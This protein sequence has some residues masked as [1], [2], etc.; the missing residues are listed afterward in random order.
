[1]TTLI[2]PFFYES[3]S[4][5]ASFTDRKEERERLSRMFEEHGRRILLYGRRRMGK[6]SL[7][8]NCVPAKSLLI[9]VDVSVAASMEELAKQL[10]H[11][12]PRPDDA[13]LARALKI[14]A[15]HFKQVTLGAGGISIAG[16]L[17]DQTGPENLGQA[18]NAL[19]ELAADRDEVWTICLDEF[20]E[21]QKLGGEKVDWKLRATIQEHRNLNYAFTGSDFRIVQWM[22][23]PNSPFFKQLELMELGPITPALM[24]AW[25]DER[26]RQGG[27]EG[28]I[29]GREIVET[30]GPCTGD[31]VRL[32]KTVFFMTTQEMS[33]GVVEKA[34]EEISNREHNGVF[35]GIWRELTVTQRLVLRA[36]ANGDPP[37]ASKTLRKQ[38]IKA[39]SSAH[40]AMVALVDRQI[41]WQPS[42]GSQA[43]E[44]PF[45]K[46]WV[47]TN[48]E[49]STAD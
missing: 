43:F 41:L 42:T 49:T 18:L 32:A 24:G 9:Y 6:T 28:F 37:T 19:N 21:I 45:L 39:A 40:S 47:A 26:A 20:Q 38:G 30:A 12:S 25:I 22:T 1:M 23:H 33:A 15:K 8:K 35:V 27:S 31:I 11:R 13:F 3:P 4:D 5:P 14:A 10:I 34:M 17:S 7:I 2:N 48:G 44:N 46:R 36:I 16:E 29:H